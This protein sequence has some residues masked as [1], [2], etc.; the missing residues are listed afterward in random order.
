[1]F[2]SNMF[3]PCHEVQKD[4][5]FVDKTELMSEIQMIKDTITKYTDENPDDIKLSINK[6]EKIID[7]LT[8]YNSGEVGLT[9]INDNGNELLL[10]KMKKI[11]VNIPIEINPNIAINALNSAVRQVLEST[12]GGRVWK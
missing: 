8:V 1:M 6:I 5:V 10:P 12:N 11:I 9:I 4:S 7:S 2:A 3:E